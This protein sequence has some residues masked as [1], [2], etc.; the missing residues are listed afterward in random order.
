M[1]RES[2]RQ[3]Q[4]AEY[5]AYSEG[6][7]TGSRGPGG[8]Q[9]QAAALRREM[10]TVHTGALGELSIDLGI[11][12]WFPSHLPGED[13]EDAKELESEEEEDRGV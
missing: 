7:L 12:G 2:F 1:P 10:V 11:Y 3:G 8:A 13:A 4:K 5:D 9:R 6:L